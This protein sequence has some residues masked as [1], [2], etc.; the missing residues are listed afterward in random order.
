MHGVFKKNVFVQ[1][2]TESV[3]SV[4]CNGIGWAQRHENL[5]TA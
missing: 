5:N 2:E 1:Q 4:L 3:A